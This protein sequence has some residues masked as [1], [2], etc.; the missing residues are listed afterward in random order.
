MR[1]CAHVRACVQRE[2]EERES[3]T[4]VPDIQLEVLT[5]PP[6]LT[7]RRDFSTTLPCFG[8]RKRG[9]QDGESDSSGGAGEGGTR[10]GPVSW[11]AQ[12]TRARISFCWLGDLEYI[13]VSEPQPPLLG[14]VGF[15][16]TPQVSV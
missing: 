13:T 8:A 5:S 14:R 3:A 10:H 7:P 15:P 11:R 12:L 16:A 9:H 6:P 1:P 4:P 2:G